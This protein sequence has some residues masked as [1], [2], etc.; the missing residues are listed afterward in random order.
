VP[1]AGGAAAPSTHA[2]PA[3][4][5]TAIASAAPA[6]PALGVP[7]DTTGAEVPITARPVSERVVELAELRQQAAGREMNIVL[8]DDTLGRV[9]L[10]LAERAGVVQ[11]VIRTDSYQGARIISSSIPALLESLSERGMPVFSQLHRGAGDEPQQRA[12]DQHAGRGRQYRQ[13]A[14]DGRRGGGS[15]QNFRLAVG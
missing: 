12:F 5:T 1:N 9:G 2:Q 7:D 14:K 4:G 10:R 8:R 6:P 15:R 11:T 3:P 13:S